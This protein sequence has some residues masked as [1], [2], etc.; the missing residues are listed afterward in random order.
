[1]M[2]FSILTMDFFYPFETFHLLMVD[3]SFFLCHV[4]STLVEKTH[5]T[6]RYHYG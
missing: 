4:S 2:G 6:T 5:F 1:M 3:V